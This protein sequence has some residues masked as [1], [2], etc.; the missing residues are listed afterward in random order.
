MQQ[1]LF[2]EERSVTVRLQEVQWCFILL[3]IVHLFIYSLTGENRDVIVQ[4]SSH[5]MVSMLLLNIK[6]MLFKDKYFSYSISLI[7]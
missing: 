4:L 5:L 3:Y 7:K 6:L 2:P 1:S